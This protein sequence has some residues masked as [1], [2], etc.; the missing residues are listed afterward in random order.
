MKPGRSKTIIISDQ[1]GEDERNL[2]QRLRSD[3]CHVIY[4]DINSICR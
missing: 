4:N 1:G 2:V 3:N